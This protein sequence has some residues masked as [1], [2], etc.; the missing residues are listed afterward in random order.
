MFNEK[1]FSFN[2][3]ENIIDIINGI[4]Q[5]V[6]DLAYEL[7]TPDEKIAYIELSTMTSEQ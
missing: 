7:M 4:Q 3:L 5:L 2:S 6:M 1:F